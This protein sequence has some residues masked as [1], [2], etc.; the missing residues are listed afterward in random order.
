MELGEKRYWSHFKS[1]LEDRA[2]I[3]E[4]QFELCNTPANLQ[5]E[6]QQN[7]II[8]LM[9]EYASLISTNERNKCE[10]L[11]EL[12]LKIA[13]SSMINIEEVDLDESTTRRIY[14]NMS[15]TREEKFIERQKLIDEQ[16]FIVPWT[17]DEILNLFKGIAKCGDNDWS[18]IC[19]QFHF[20]SFRTPNSLAHKWEKFKIV[21]IQDIQRIFNEKGIDISKWEWIKCQIHKMEVKCG[22]ISQKQNL[23]QKPPHSVYQKSYCAPVIDAQEKIPTYKAPEQLPNVTLKPMDDLNCDRKSDIFHQLSLAYDDCMNTFKHSIENGNFSLYNVRKYVSEK[24]TKPLCPKYFQLKHIEQNVEE[25]KQTNPISQPIENPNKTIEI[26]KKSHPMSLKKLF[27]EKKKAQLND[28]Q[29][30]I[31]TPNN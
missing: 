18:E 22:Y 24:E 14:E 1:D 21:M 11:R 15:R 25:N 9:N 20:Q 5:Y 7:N 30:Q 19:E 17:D 10:Y 31:N 12:E 27:L 29:L 23:V 13:E 2:K 26:E 16:A 28:T 3:Y 8:E 4:K 6:T